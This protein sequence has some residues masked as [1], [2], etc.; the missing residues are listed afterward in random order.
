[1]IAMITIPSIP[2]IAQTTFFTAD[3]I[4]VQIP[5]RQYFT[6]TDPNFDTDLSIHRQRKYI[7]VIDI[8]PQR[9]QR[10]TALLDLFRTGDLGATQTAAHLDLDP[11]GTHPE[12]RCYGHF[13]GPF[14]VDTVLDLTSDGIT[15]DIRIQ[16]RA[17]DLQDVDLNIVFTRELL[18]LFLDPVDLATAL[19]DDDTGLGCMDRHDQLVQRTLDNYLGDPSF[20]DTGIQVGSDLVVLDQL[21][22]IV[23]L[24][25]IPVGFP[26]TDDP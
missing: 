21:G 8:H 25:A 26:T 1:M 13:N 6:L 23:F 4:R 15:N 17:T 16:L 24:A 9:V 10:R 5:L 12:R 20:I 7:R 14:I 3:E 11:F 22:S 19:T 2:A 18:Q